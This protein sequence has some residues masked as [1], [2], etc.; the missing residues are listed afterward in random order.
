M[1]DDHSKAMELVSKMEAQLPI[2]ARSTTALERLMK[3]QD[4]CSPQQLQIK[5]V[6]YKR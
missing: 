2:P 1:I 5:H 3:E 4:V 6:F